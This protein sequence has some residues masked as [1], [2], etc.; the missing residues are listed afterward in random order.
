VG[1]GVLEMTHE[2]F[3]RMFMTPLLPYLHGDTHTIDEQS[4]RRFLRTFLT[5]ANLDAGLSVIANPE[6]GEIFYLSREE[7]RRVVEITLEEVGGRAPVL[8]GAL[9]VT[10]AGSVEVALDAAEL[11]VD[12]LFVFPAIGAQD[13]AVA[14]DADN[15][16][17]VM[18]DMF[19]AIAREVDLPMVVHPVATPSIRYG[20]GLSAAATRY[21]CE[22]VPNVVGWKMTYNYNGYR[23][24]ARVLRSL[25]R[26][27]EILGALAKFFHENLAND[28]FDGTSS[29]AWNYAP[30]P[31]M[32]HILAWRAGDVRRATEIW[33]GGLAQVH[34]YVFAEMSRLHVRYKA[35][36]W[37][38]GF[39]DNPLMRPPMPKPRRAEIATLYALLRALDLPTI[40]SA[41]VDQFTATL[42]EGALVATP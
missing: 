37:L 40:E 42:I 30:E 9:D 4:Y 10:T 28:Q 8:A 2:P 32:E 21:V 20:I 27:V 13:V 1:N 18:T 12:G 34:E 41:E 24:I 7:K 6:A 3:G 22:H 15:Y 39:I 33:N 35:A 36:A 23:E 11:G 16:P 17:E 5:E 26:R 19:L 29:G 31:M 38:R 25:D 14:W